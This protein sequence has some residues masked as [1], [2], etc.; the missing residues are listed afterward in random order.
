M[1]AMF[2]AEDHAFMSRALALAER[3]RD[4]ATPNP[5]VGCVIVKDGRIVGEGWHRR[6]GGPHAETIALR[7]A[8]RASRGADLYV[9]LEPCNHHGRTPPCV[10]AIV[11]AG[12][13]SV[14]AAA[15]DPNPDVA[16]GGLAALARAGVR[17]RSAEASTA[18]RARR[19]NEKFFVRAEAGR[20][21]VLLKW[22]ASLDGKIAAAR[23]AE[24]RITGPD[25]RRRALLLREEH[26][27][28]LVG[29]GT[30]ISD[31]PRLTRRLGRAGARP[32]LRIVLDGN[33]RLP[34]RAR[35]LR[36]A[37]DVL[38]V[39]SSRADGRKIARLRRR[40]AE[41]WTLPAGRDGAIAPAALLRRLFQRGIGSVLVE[42]GARTH[43]AFLAAGVADAVAVFL[44]PR[45]VG[46][47]S[48]PGAVAG[49][50]FSLPS[51]PRLSDVAVERLGEDLLVTG[52][53][54]PPR[55]L[56]RR[57]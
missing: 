7:K 18:R 21:F 38:I 57:R 45:L 33:L 3:G 5:N 55:S 34:E 16:G 15:R 27:A 22:A 10:D 20:P 32:Y 42:G 52:R 28:V 1:S 23:G 11:A 29:A 12:V 36:D 14:L 26:D 56:R 47:A 50:G 17:V 46:G 43:A 9:T 51:A 30:V 53:I 4:T 54:G 40:G 6:A 24:R 13:R 2:S 48:A 19:Q 35:V 25:A 8:G 39:T 44:A 31:D 37:A 49:A 41:V